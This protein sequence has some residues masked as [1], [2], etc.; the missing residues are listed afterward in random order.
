MPATLST[1]ECAF[2]TVERGLTAEGGP[3]ERPLPTFP[4]RRFVAAGGLTIVHEG[5]LVYEFV[6]DGT[7][8]AL[9]L[10]RATGILSRPDLPTRPLD[11]GPPLPLRG[12][13]VRGHHVL[14]YGVAVGDGDPC[15]FLA[16]V[17]G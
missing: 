4:S 5:L 10:L 12:S 17:S 9:T 3:H 2:A 11:A 7:A 1:A 14:R 16:A 8:L 6:D 15:G 13:Q